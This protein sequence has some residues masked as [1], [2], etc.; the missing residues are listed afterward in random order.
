MNTNE[1]HIFQD[2]EKWEHFLHRFKIKID[3][4]K[5]TN[6]ITL[7]ENLKTIQTELK[8]LRYYLNMHFNSTEKYKVVEEVIDESYEEI[9]ENITQLKKEYKRLSFD[10]DPSKCQNGISLKKISDEVIKIK[11]QIKTLYK[12]SIKE[13][14]EGKVK[15]A[16]EDTRSFIQDM[17]D[18]TFRKCA[19]LSKDLKESAKNSIDK[20][21][22]ITK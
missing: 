12:T 16:F 9:K 2:I 13:C 6:F 19:E 8:T 22:N 15:K 3:E 20:L 7:K 18:Y 21:S 4:I 5:P 1:K 11:Q 14:R 17:D 10:T